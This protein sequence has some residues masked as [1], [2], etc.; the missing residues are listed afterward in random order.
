MRIAPPGGEGGDV[1][2][3]IGAGVGES[4]GGNA[5]LHPYPDPDRP[6]ELTT[7]EGGPGTSAWD[8]PSSRA[9]L[10][11]AG[12]DCVRPRLARSTRRRLESPRCVRRVTDGR[13]LA[14]PG[15]DDAQNRR[16]PVDPARRVPLGLRALRRPRRSERQQGQLEGPAPLEPRHQPEPARTRARPLL[17]SSPTG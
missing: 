8:G 12:V 6:A 14:P 9:P 10:P 11:C 1:K 16:P 5:D 3:G 17:R 13:G 15:P 2:A 7:G 4:G